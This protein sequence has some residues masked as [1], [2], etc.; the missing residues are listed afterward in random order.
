M[1]YERTCLASLR[2]QKRMWVDQQ[3]YSMYKKSKEPYVT[4]KGTVNDNH[5]SMG[6]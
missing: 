1:A 6:S 4:H 2:V 5:K 3:G